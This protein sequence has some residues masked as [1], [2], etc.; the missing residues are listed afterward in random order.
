[1]DTNAQPKPER[2]YFKTYLSMVENA[3]GT[4]MFRR[5][6]LKR[7]DGSE[8]DAI[9]DGDNACAFFVSSVLR[10]FDKVNG[11]HGTVEST[12]R[13]MEKSDWTRVEHPEPGDAISWEPHQ[14]PDG[15][16]GHI[17]FYL[18]D[19]RAVSTSTSKKTVT[20]H[21]LH[22]G[23]AQRQVVAVYRFTAWEQ[24]HGER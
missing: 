5:V 18:G 16:H 2:L 12:I 23:T 3:P 1:M 9:G 19:N 4:N 8:F 15:P 10:L 6:Y 14:S 17:G 21:N 22:F 13:D 7:P 11:V 24:P 20:I